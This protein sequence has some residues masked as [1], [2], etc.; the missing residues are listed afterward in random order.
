MSSV[1]VDETLSLAPCFLIHLYGSAGGQWQGGNGAREEWGEVG[2]GDEFSGEGKGPVRRVITFYES[3]MACIVGK[4]CYT[5]LF[6]FMGSAWHA[7]LENVSYDVFISTKS[8]IACVDT[9]KSE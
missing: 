2:S 8:G 1:R 5:M 4:G 3:G 9:P 6:S 7:W